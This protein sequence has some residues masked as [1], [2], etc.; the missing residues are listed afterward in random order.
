MR[1]EQNRELFGFLRKQLRLRNH[2]Q[3]SLQKGGAAPAV[4]ETRPRLDGRQLLRPDV[5]Q[6]EFLKEGG[7]RSIVKGTNHPRHIP[8]GRTLDAPFPEGPGWF[9]LEID[10][11]KIFPRIEHL[12]KMVVAVAADAQPADWLVGHPLE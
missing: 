9:A 6:L 3:V 7:V 4:P 1:V 10:Y 5:P 11:D 8:K 12:A 2:L